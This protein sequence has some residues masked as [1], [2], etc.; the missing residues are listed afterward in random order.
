MQKLITDALAQ[1]KGLDIQV[2]DVRKVAEFTDYMVIVSGTSSRHVQTLAEKAVAALRPHGRRPIGVEGQKHG[3]WV[4]IDFGEVVTH[5]MRP[6]A[7]D[8]YNLEK[9]WGETPHEA[10]SKAIVRRKV[11]K[12]TK[13]SK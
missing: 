5:V 8:F 12:R 2:L 13:I 3:D 10:P 11:K 6:Q 7:R 9:L 1:A 4:L